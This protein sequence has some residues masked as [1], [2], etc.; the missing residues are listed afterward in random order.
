MEEVSSKLVIISGASGAVGRDFL[1][2]FSKLK[3][4]DI[5]AIARRNFETKADNF[6]LI[7]LDLLDSKKV[8]ESIETLPFSKY[9]E[10]VF[11]HSVGMFKYEPDGNP[12]IDHDNDGID[13]DVY[14]TNV[15]TFLNVARPLYQALK[16]SN[17]KLKLSFYGVG[18]VS[19]KHQ[20]KF[21]QSYTKSK[22][23]LRSIIYNL[24]QENPE[25]VK[26]MMF[27]VS[28][29]DTEKENELRPNA[30]KTYWLSGKEI[31]IASVPFILHEEPGTWKQLDIYK[32]SPLFESG[33]YKNLL[34][35]K[36]RWEEQMLQTLTLRSE[37]NAEAANEVRTELTREVPQLDGP[38]FKFN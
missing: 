8:M 37:Y 21:W 28:T 4:F 24:I 15:E 25:S 11:V 20:V 32:N 23:I 26:G 13:D 9:K 19:D 36:L 29:V 35:V 2:E 34:A 16:N 7:E 30:E 10:I 6:N 17:N 38:F 14:R 33:Y 1:E 27:N 12:S 3:E 5:V 31:A 22:D 18:S